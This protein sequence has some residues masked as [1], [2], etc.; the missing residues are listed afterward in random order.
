MMLFLCF[1]FAVHHYDMHC[2]RSVHIFREYVC[3]YESNI[4]RLMPEYALSLFTF[5]IFAA[6]VAVAIVALFILL[7]LRFTPDS[8]VVD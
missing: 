7:I 3:M 6:V 8:C 5:T 2:G 4:F 1:A